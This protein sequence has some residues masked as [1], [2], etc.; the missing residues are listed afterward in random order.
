M[1]KFLSKTVLFASALCV[2]AAFVGCEQDKTQE[3]QPKDDIIISDVEGGY[4]TPAVNYDGPVSD[5]TYLDGNVVNYNG[6]TSDGYG[7]SKEEFYFSVGDDDIYGEFY[8]P[9]T[10]KDKNPCVIL[11]HSAFLTAEAVSDYCVAFAKRGYIAYAYDFR[12]GGLNT[13]SSLSLDDMTLFSE[14]EDLKA[15]LDGVSAFDIVDSSNIYLFG[16]GQGGVVSAI[17]AND[18]ADK[19]KGLVMLYPMFNLPD[20]AKSTIS[21][22]SFAGSFGMSQ[23]SYSPDKYLAAIDGYDIYEHIGAY[24]GDV[25]IIRGSDDYVVTDS[26]IKKAVDIYEKCTYKIIEG[27]A[28]GFNTANLSSLDAKEYDDEVWSYIDEYLK[29]V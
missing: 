8:V 19:V 9:N 29:T 7:Y 13:R 24:K 28:H 6:D 21:W 3:E 17:V 14:V 25:L 5:G 16:S 1:K 23:D 12:G 18:Y 26:Y 4:A 20:L 27:A 10:G 22:W 2:S 11:S 15:V